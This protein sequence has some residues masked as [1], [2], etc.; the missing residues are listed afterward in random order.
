M[1]QFL[2]VSAKERYPEF[3]DLVFSPVQGDSF[4]G[5]AASEL[6]PSRSTPCW[7]IFTP[8]CEVGDLAYEAR[9]ALLAGHALQSTLLGRVLL[10]VIE[11]G[12]G[13]A[14]FYASD[15]LRLPA[16]KTVQEV[17]GLLTE[18][19]L[20]SNGANLELYAAWLP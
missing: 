19:L 11:R 18:Q 16:M 8:G 1:T 9:Q 4:L 17:I 7:S 14:L 15:Y 5:Q 6:F 3:A 12:D 10:H 2:L 13:F 20:A